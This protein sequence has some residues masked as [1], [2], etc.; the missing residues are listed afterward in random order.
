MTGPTTLRVIVPMKPAYEA[1]SRL[2]SVLDSDGR[3]ALSLHL[4]QHVLCVVALPSVGET[5]VS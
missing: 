4:L 1:K 5:W 2:T 3:V